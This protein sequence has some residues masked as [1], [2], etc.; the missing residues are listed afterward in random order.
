LDFSGYKF[1]SASMSRCNKSPGAGINPQ[2]VALA[3]ASLCRNLDFSGHK[4]DAARF[5]TNAIISSC[6]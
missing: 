6:N 2:Y 5:Q 1:D 3:S 4:F